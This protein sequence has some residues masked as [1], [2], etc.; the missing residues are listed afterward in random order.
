[1]CVVFECLLEAQ[2][3]PMCLAALSQLARTDGSSA[4]SSDVGMQ[5]I[6]LCA[7]LSVARARVFV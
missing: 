3:P 6:C 1:M 2:L 4:L 7:A 5:R